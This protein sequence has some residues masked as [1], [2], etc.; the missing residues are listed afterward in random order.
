MRSAHAT[1]SLLYQFLES[2][3]P[4]IAKHKAG[5]PERIGWESSLHLGIYASGRD[6]QIRE[7]VVVEIDDAGAPPYIASF[8]AQ[9]GADGDVVEVPFP[10][11]AV[12]D[13]GI[14]GEVRFEDVEV[15]VEVVV[16][17]AHTHAGLFQPVF[18]ERH[19]SFQTLLAKGAVVL[20]AKQPARRG[21]AG[22]I[23]IR[24]TVVVVVCCDHCHWI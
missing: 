9:A 20:V 22:D 3:V 16:A 6:E 15:S 4:Q 11:V 24:P 2:S 21:I 19:P 23:D 12:E 1:A 18:A 7:A 10:V 17:D 5:S 8:D 14:V 13:I